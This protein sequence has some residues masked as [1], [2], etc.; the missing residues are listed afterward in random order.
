MVPVVGTRPRPDR[1]LLMYP[2]WGLGSEIKLINV[3][4]KV[5]YKCFEEK[6]NFVF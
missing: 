3:Y 5:L 2:Y 6:I 1:T 4:S